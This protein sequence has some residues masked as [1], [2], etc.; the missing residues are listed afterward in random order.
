MIICALVELSLPGETINDPDVIRPAWKCD[1]LSPYQEKYLNANCEAWIDYTTELPE[2]AL[3]PE[4][5]MQAPVTITGEWDIAALEWNPDWPYPLIQVI[6]WVDCQVG[7]VYQDWTSYY[8][9]PKKD[10]NTEFGDATS[11]TISTA[12]TPID[13]PAA[14]DEWDKLIECHSDGLAFYTCVWGLYVLDN[15]KKTSGEVTTYESIDESADFNNVPAA[16]VNPPAAPNVWDQHEN[17]Y[18]NGDVVYEWNWSIWNIVDTDKEYCPAVTD[19]E[20]FTNDWTNSS[21]DSPDESWNPDLHYEVAYII[22]ENGSQVLATETPNKASMPAYQSGNTFNFAN[23]WPITNNMTK[24]HEIYDWPDCATAVLISRSVKICQVKKFIW[25]D[26]TP[27]ACP[28]NFPFT[29]TDWVVINDQA[30]ADAY[31][32]A[33]CPWVAFDNA[34]CEYVRIVDEWTPP[35]EDMPVTGN[36]IARV[37][38]NFTNAWGN[39]DYDITL[40]LLGCW[41]QPATTGDC[42]TID[43]KDTTNGWV[44]ETLTGKVGDDITTF[45]STNAWPTSILNFVTSWAVV[46]GFTFTFAKKTRWRNQWHWNNNWST[47]LISDAVWLDSCWHAW[48]NPIDMQIC[49]TITPVSPD[50]GT[51]TNTDNFDTLETHFDGW[52]FSG[53]N[54]GEFTEAWSWDH[55]TNI[56]WFIWSSDWGL[57]LTYNVDNINT[58]YEF[59]QQQTL[60]YSGVDMFDDKWY[61]SSFPWTL[62]HLW[63]ND[64]KED[65]FLLKTEYYNGLY[66]EKLENNISIVNPWS[67]QAKHRDVRWEMNAPNATTFN[68]R[69]RNFFFPDNDDTFNSYEYSIYAECPWCFI[70]QASNPWPWTTLVNYTHK[71]AGLYTFKTYANSDDYPFPATVPVNGQPYHISQWALLFY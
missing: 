21:F 13:P 46:D 47:W 48:Y 45:T 58:S 30:G 66:S 20:N 16:P 29:T 59:F 11:T 61:P 68:I 7:Y 17:N 69:L 42:V 53:S 63:L 70:A 3:A 65:W 31:A 26:W 10:L 54:I 2:W 40:E 64:T 38:T 41:E 55:C 35:I 18:H 8:T 67:A 57:Q 28:L 33:K 25:E 44:L 37:T 15:V 14:K 5:C 23:T 9:P 56:D 51:S 36:P 27:L 1:N 32:L 12:W 24:V 71:W 6:D 50:C 60:I 4:C 39:G 52:V 19:I 62:C 34:T 22:L 43:I 49:I